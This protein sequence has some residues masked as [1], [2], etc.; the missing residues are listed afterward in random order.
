[1]RIWAPIPPC[2]LDRQR[3]LA[4][5]R[6]L[7]AIWS[8]LV[9]HKK[10]YQNHPEVKRWRGWLPQL[11]L[12]HQ[13]LVREMERRGYNHA[14]PPKPKIVFV[15]NSSRWGEWPP[16]WQ[17]IEHMRSLLAQKQEPRH[18]RPLQNLHRPVL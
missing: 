14:S 15:D 18:E 1:M 13:Y 10:G 11:W 6:E 2:C 16:T 8:I 4:E 12:R 7:H 9:N 3:L 5:H 17:P